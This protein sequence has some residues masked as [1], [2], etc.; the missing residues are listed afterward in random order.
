MK[1]YARANSSQK[2]REFSLPQSWRP[3]KSGNLGVF[4]ASYQDQRYFIADVKAY[5]GGQWRYEV[6]LESSFQQFPNKRQIPPHLL[7]IEVSAP[8]AGSTAWPPPWATRKDEI[9]ARTGKIA[10]I[11]YRSTL[12][13]NWQ[14]VPAQGER[15]FPLVVPRRG[16]KWEFRVR[17]QNS[18]LK[19][20]P[21]FPMWSGRYFNTTYQFSDGAI[22]RSL[23]SY[24][25]TSDN[26][27]DSTAVEKIGF[28]KVLKQGHLFDLQAQ[29][30][31]TFQAQFKIG[32]DEFSPGDYQYEDQQRLLQN[33]TFSTALQ[34]SG[35]Y[36]GGAAYATM[37][38]GST[39]SFEAKLE[40]GDGVWDRHARLRVR[41][42]AVGGPD[43]G[44]SV[45]ING[46]GAKD[47]IVSPDREGR[48][49]ATV[50]APSKVTSAML[51]AEILD[52][53]GK[54]IRT[55][56]L[57]LSFA[58]PQIRVFYGNWRPAPEQ[59]A[60]VFGRSI[61]ISRL[62]PSSNRSFSIIQEKANVP[63]FLVNLTAP[64]QKVS[65]RRVWLSGASA[66][67]NA[68]LAYNFPTAEYEAKNPPSAMQYFRADPTLLGTRQ[69]AVFA[70]RVGIAPSNSSRQKP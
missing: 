2:W 57:S 65:A 40:S 43:L 3:L 1:A 45:Q 69:M 70:V 20:S 24:E 30:T 64:R 28:E 15:G 67:T 46:P 5:G 59:G 21:I 68:D 25:S 32:P 61:W 58:A 13:P 49:S 66:K 54:V 42:R 31:N 47:D 18:K 48:V 33:A 36:S 8:I 60:D 10:A 26:N 14:K 12:H 34:K 37:I 7:Q 17:F 16:G 44:D 6:R 63:I 38:L 11:E 52:D 62:L 35:S 27:E 51:N 39:Q 41:F 55:S 22:L 53:G 19:G 50:R 9:D 56:Q 4:T 23:G 29:A